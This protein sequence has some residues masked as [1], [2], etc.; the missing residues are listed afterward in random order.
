MFHLP[1]VRA[2]LNGSRVE[3]VDRSRS[4]HH[5]THGRDFTICY[6]GSLDSQNAVFRNTFVAT[7]T[8]AG[9]VINKT[10]VVAIPAG[11]SDRYSA[12]STGELRPPV[13]Y[14][15]VIVVVLGGGD[16]ESRSV[17]T[18]EQEEPVITSLFLV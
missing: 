16:D 9:Q 15:P 17:L 4:V 18:P 11:W 7:R 1:V 13:V 6:F 10:M 3:L 8:E 12:V 2:E 14:V 5:G